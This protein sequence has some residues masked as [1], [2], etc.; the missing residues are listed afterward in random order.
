MLHYMQ[1][2]GVFMWPIFCLAIIALAIALEKIYYYS[3]ISRDSTTKFK[4]ELT[5][6]IGNCDEDEVINFCKHYK[7][8]LAK[9]TIK[10]LNFAKNDCNL[11]K[12]ELKYNIEVAIDDEISGFEKGSW[13]LGICVGAAPQLGLL[14]T[15]VG[16]IKSF[17]ALGE[18][19]GASVVADGISQALYT[20]A[21]GLLVAI[22]V[23]VIHVVIGKKNDSLIKDLDRL[24]M[25]LI[26]R[27][28]KQ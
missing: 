3:F 22:P 1:A 10:I 5:N 19:D 18:L 24:E 14:G 28:K 26:K 21:F 8:P 25:L 15:I 6:L 23:L 12:D 4:L 7:N 13:V 20:T 2:G 17:G 16:M 9:A 11:D 27:F